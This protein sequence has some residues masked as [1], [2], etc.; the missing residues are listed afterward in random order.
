[1]SVGFSIPMIMVNPHELLGGNE[2]ARVVGSF[3]ACPD[4]APFV[5]SLIF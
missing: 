2:I 1:M 5:H 3:G 4:A